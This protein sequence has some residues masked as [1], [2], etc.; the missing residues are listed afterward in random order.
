MELRQD[1]AWDASG[2][3]TRVRHFMW[4]NNAKKGW[5]EGDVPALQV[6]SRLREKILNLFHRE[7]VTVPSR[8]CLCGEQ[9]CQSPSS[10][11]SSPAPGS[12]WAAWASE[13]GGTGRRGF[14]RPQATPL[15]PESSRVASAGKRD[16]NLSSRILQKSLPAT[17]YSPVEKQKP[18]AI[19][20]VLILEDGIF[21]HLLDLR[22]CKGAS[23]HL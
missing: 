8:R 10:S 18:E 21:K 14:H 12:G 16:G 2:C 4:A 15:A 19:F 17:A 11:S 20:S 22:S 9:S 6:V 3:C 1:A 13:Q 23:V 5:L 7:N